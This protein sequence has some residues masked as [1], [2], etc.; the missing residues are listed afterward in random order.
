[1]T[2]I[3]AKLA[4]IRKRTVQFFT[5]FPSNLCPDSWRPEAVA[6]TLVTSPGARKLGKRYFYAARKPTESDVW[7]VWQKVEDL[8]GEMLLSID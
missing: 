1:M 5:F 2:I 7:K 6:A 4:W 8:Q 3:T